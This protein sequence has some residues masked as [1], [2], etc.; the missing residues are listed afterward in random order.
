MHSVN[1][2]ID[3]TWKVTFTNSDKKTTYKISRSSVYVLSCF[4]NKSSCQ[5]INDSTLAPSDDNERYPLEQGWIKVGPIHQSDTFLYIRMKRYNITLEVHFY[6]NQGS[7][8]PEYGVG[9][10]GSEFLLF[11]LL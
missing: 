8:S 10:K 11:F 5:E 4:F 6:S 2:N 9:I 1:I 3:G 7:L